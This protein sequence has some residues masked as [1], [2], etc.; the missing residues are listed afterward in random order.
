MEIYAK[1][2][3]HLKTIKRED[4]K[5]QKKLHNLSVF[6]FKLVLHTIQFYRSKFNS[7]PFQIPKQSLF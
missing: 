4:A 6:A 7:N 1:R 2:Y 3:N 5:T